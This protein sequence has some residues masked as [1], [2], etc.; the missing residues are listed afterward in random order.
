MLGA[1]AAALI[2]L[3]TLANPEPAHKLGPARIAR[4][5]HGSQVL[6]LAFSP[7]GAQ[8]A[9]TSVAGRV[10]VRSLENGWENEQCVGFRGYA[11]AV[12]FSPDGRFLAAAGSARGVLWD[13][14]SSSASE[15]GTKIVPP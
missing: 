6:S 5:E 15:P 8:I 1:I 3:A 10:T 4:G 13:V 14:S 12:A 9:T 11:R 7:T 2:A